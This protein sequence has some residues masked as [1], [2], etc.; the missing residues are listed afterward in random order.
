MIF[1]SLSKSSL[2]YL[3]LCHVG[4]IFLLFFVPL[5]FFLSLPAIAIASWLAAVKCV[6]EPD[7]PFFSEGAR[8][9]TKDFVAFKVSQV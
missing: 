3:L 2:P 7:P 4:F 5:S 1:K 6:A 9:T 8:E